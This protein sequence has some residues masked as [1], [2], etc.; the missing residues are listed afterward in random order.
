MK[1]NE[2]L[3]LRDWVK[4]NRSWVLQERPK[5]ADV[6]VKAE[7]DL[8]FSCPSGAIADCMDY[9]KLPRRLGKDAAKIQGLTEERNK[10]R[11]AFLKL[12]M[13]TS[14]A[15]DLANELR[16]ILAFDAEV[17]DLL[18]DKRVG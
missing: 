8:S 3:L 7:T 6:R 2:V 10:Y 18:K 1:A 9:E 4:R 5:M 15:P 12:V 16:E 17:D 13:I 11:S 14:V